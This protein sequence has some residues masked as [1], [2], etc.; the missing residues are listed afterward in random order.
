MSVFDIV[1]KFPAIA[2]SDITK[3]ISKETLDRVLYTYTD[4]RTGCTLVKYKRGTLETCTPEE[5]AALGQLRSVIAHGDRVIGISPSKI[6]TLDRDA[7]RAA[8][9]TQPMELVEGTMVNACCHPETG[10]WILSTRS[11]IG[12]GNRFYSNTPQTFREMFEEAMARTTMTLGDLNKD[13]CYSFVLKHPGNRLVNAVAEPELYLVG[14]SLLSEADSTTV[15]DGETERLGAESSRLEALGVHLPVSYP[16][17]AE[18]WAAGASTQELGDLVRAHHPAGYVP[19]GFVCS[20]ADDGD[21]ST[22]KFV[23]PDYNMLRDLRGNQGNLKYRYLELMQEAR[24]HLYLQQ[25][26]EHA[27]LFMQYGLELHEFAT[28]LHSSYR[29]CFCAHKKR[30]K[31]YPFQL[32]VIM[33][34]LHGI[35]LKMLKPIGQV[36]T[37][38]TVYYHLLSLPTAKLLYFMNFEAKHA[39]KEVAAATDDSTDAAEAAARRELD[40]AMAALKAATGDA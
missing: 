9:V 11:S 33:Y 2:V 30:L 36:T 40:S 23:F 20:L 39:K 19:R 12:A 1:S 8:K 35:Y 38:S 6:V 17:L 21:H 31:E 3:D 34:D 15:I 10:E 37:L 29:E 32:R 18:A 25:F 27:D 4:K 7:D 22:Y 5:R 26:P 14:V 16:E 28:T 13:Y 24:L